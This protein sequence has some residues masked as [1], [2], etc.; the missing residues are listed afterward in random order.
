M[1]IEKIDKYI[2]KLYC[3]WNFK[4]NG[5]NYVTFTEH[6]LKPVL[7]EKWIFKEH[8]NMC[9]SLR[10]FSSSSTINRYLWKFINWKTHI[11][12]F[13]CESLSQVIHESLWICKILQK[14]KVLYS[15]MISFVE[16]ILHG[17][18]MKTLWTSLQP[19]EFFLIASDVNPSSI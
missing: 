11:Y 6:I 1:L 4:M 8:Q 19:S 12:K 15:S 16:F 10:K 13:S 14:H 5:L 18:T 7:S 2:Y 9:T 17:Y 3:R